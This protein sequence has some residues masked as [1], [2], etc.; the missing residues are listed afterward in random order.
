M[1]GAVGGLSNPMITRRTFAKMLAA[2]P[3]LGF[4]RKPL[5]PIQKTPVWYEGQY[6]ASICN[7]KWNSGGSKWRPVYDDGTFGEWQS[8]RQAGFL[9]DPQ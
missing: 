2:I 9:P 1:G 3:L 6:F 4:T 5:S 7:G 8:G